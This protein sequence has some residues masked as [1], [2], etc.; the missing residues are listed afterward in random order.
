[1]EPNRRPHQGRP[2]IFV[3][4]AGCAHV[5]AQKKKAADRA[6]GGIAAACCC[7][8]ISRNR[9]TYG[10]FDIKDLATCALQ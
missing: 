2:Y 4:P 9:A 7:L 8:L 5:V 1:M 6:E 3:H 10:P